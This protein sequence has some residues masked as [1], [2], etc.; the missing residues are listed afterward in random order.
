MPI[1]ANAYNWRNNLYDNGIIVAFGKWENLY[2]R[3]KNCNYLFALLNQNKQ[4]PH[5]KQFSC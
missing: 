2:V 3:Q 1:S 4:Y 5:P